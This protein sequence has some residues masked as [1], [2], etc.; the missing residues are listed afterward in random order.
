MKA[1]ADLPAAIGSDFE[2]L[3]P[4]LIAEQETPPW[5]RAG[6]STVYV[7]TGR[8]ALFLIGR[9][10]SRRGVTEVLVPSYLCESMVE[11]FLRLG[12]RI[13]ALDVSRDLRLRRSAALDS[14]GPRSAVLL[15]S[16]FGREPDGE[17]R[18]LARDARS[19]GAVVIEDETHRPFSPGGVD[20]DVAFA[21]LRKVLPV[22]DGAYI[23]GDAEV[24][25]D[26][27]GLEPST[28]RR[29]AAM[30]AKRASLQG[31][32]DADYRSKFAVAN[33][34][35]EDPDR[36]FLATERSIDTLR[37]LPYAKLARIRRDNAALLR[38]AL[39]GSGVGYLDPSVSGTPTHLVVTVDQPATIQS[40]L[41]AERIF[42]PIHWP[43]VDEIDS[44]GDWRSDVL[45]LPVDHRYGASDMAR[46]ADALLRAVA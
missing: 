36:L 41:A 3:T 15:A 23:R 24:A 46:V 17:H 19:R 31:G 29:W 25:A 22:A 6:E 32:S 44:R 5:H 42:C 34:Q 43:R 14:L 33:E 35:L 26:A 30:D 7:E 28:S 13:G 40:R 10:L 8:Q 27:R 39:N 16:Y 1:D 21:S 2:T 18:A 38:S 12:L 11:P 20:A 37:R 9:V 45:S 4:V